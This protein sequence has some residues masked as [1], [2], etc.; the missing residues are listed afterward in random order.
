M[1][2]L[3]S[4]VI[5]RC[6]CLPADSFRRSTTLHKQ[7]TSQLLLLVILTRDDICI[8]E[9]M[10]MSFGATLS[11]ATNLAVIQMDAYIIF[12]STINKLSLMQ[13]LSF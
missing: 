5:P 1:S 11:A 9:K 6:T 3:T 13:R 8:R 7:V 2:T 4:C 12:R 10:Y